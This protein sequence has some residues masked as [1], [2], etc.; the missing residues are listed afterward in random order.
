MTPAP[1]P[2]APMSPMGLSPVGPLSPPRPLSPVR[3][4]TPPKQI[5]PKQV[6]SPPA[7]SPLQSKSSPSPTIH[8]QRPPSP[9]GQA[10]QSSGSASSSS[11]SGSE[12]GSESSDDSEDEV[13]PPPTKG[14][15]TP[16]SVSPKT[17]NLIEEPLPAIEEST[18]NQTR[19]NLRSFFEKTAASHGE[20]NTENKQP[21]VGVLVFRAASCVG[22]SSLG[23]S[24][25][26]A[27]SVYVSRR[28]NRDDQIGRAV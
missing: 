9:P 4:P 18:H 11:D 17:D 22:N 8:H 5:T 24:F 28:F 13:S 25:L 20:Q 14:P 19:W 16:P 6:L 2:L 21:Q 23:P 7:V 26:P 27:T 15:S 12:S 10:P 1:P 3:P